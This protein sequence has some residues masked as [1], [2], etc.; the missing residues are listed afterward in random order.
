[1]H[2]TYE[3]FSL[4]TDRP[5]TFGFRVRGKLTTKAMA[6][7][8]SRLEEIRNDGG[9]AR[10][11]IDLVR[12]VGFELGAFR[13]KLQ[14]MKTLWHTLDR[15]AYVID[16][17]WMSAAVN[18]IDA[19]TPMHIRAFDHSCEDEAMTWLLAEGGSAQVA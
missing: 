15:V 13:E 6:A 1:M 8:I 7:F 9:R 17:A 10:C 19:F 11:Y 18:L 4:H 5:H 3:F 2:D 12:Y 14:H 16:P